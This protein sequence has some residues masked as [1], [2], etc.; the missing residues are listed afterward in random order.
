MTQ[1]QTE[2][3]HHPSAWYGRD[4]INDSSWIVSLEPRH[5]A[6]RERAGPAQGAGAAQDAGT[7]PEGGPA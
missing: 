2:I 7:T 5:L 1:I 4:L 3:I 6:I